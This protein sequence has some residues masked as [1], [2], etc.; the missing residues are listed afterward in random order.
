MTRIA[1]TTYRTKT[2]TTEIAQ[3]AQR[4]YALADTLVERAERLRESAE[5]L[6]SSAH[7]E[8]RL[9]SVDL[10]GQRALDVGHH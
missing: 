9:E 10:R 5:M 7:V 6:I 4:L 1:P 8:V 3:Q 2:E